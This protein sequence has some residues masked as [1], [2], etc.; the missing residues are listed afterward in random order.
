MNKAIKKE[1]EKQLRDKNPPAEWGKIITRYFDEIAGSDT[2]VI[3]RA[4]YVLGWGYWR[5]IKELNRQGFYMSKTVFYERIVEALAEIAVRAAYKHLI[6][7]YEETEKKKVAYICSPYR[8]DTTEGVNSN[9]AYAR[10]L[11]KCAIEE[12]YTPICP[13]LYIT[14]V[15]NDSNPAER[16]QGLRVGLELLK[17][18]DVLIIGGAHGISDGMFAEIKQAEQLGLEILEFNI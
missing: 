10:Q 8:S 1:I 18:C 15:L 16:E 4:R 14:E 9:K 13:H 11:V 2:A 3:L 17:A 7:P 6:S 12:G 5:T